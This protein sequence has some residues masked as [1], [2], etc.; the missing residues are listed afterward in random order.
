MA[1]AASMVLRRPVLSSFWHGRGVYRGAGGAGGPTAGKHPARTGRLP[2]HPGH[3]GPQS[4]ARGGAGGGADR[5]PPGGGGG[6]GGG[7][8]P[9][10]PPPP[11]PP[12]FPP[13]VRP[14]PGERPA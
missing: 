14:R 3:H 10:P 9:T 5:A 1:G 6:G 2:R 8:R 4:R 7:G 11:G 13:T 12:P